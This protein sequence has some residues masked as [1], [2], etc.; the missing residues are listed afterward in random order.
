MAA[1]TRFNPPTGWPRLGRAF[2]HGVVAPEGRTL[3]ITGQVA[4]DGE[5]KLVGAGDCEAQTR[6]CF[7]NILHILNAVGGRFEDIVSLTIYFLDPDDL[8]AI[9]KV[10][11]ERLS[12]DTA[13]TSTVIQAA[14][15]VS[16]DLLVEVVPIAVIPFARYHDPRW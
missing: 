2:N 11:A 8:P 15:L 10:R 16:P 7:D 4:W 6:Q 3:H 14:G 9:Q 1:M 12:P 5:G 13:P